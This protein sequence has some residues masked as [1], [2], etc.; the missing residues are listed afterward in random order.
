[1]DNQVSHGPRLVIEEQIRD[2]SGLTVDGLDGATGHVS[3]ASEAGIDRL[4][5]HDRSSVLGPGQVRCNWRNCRARERHHHGAQPVINQVDRSRRNQ[6]LVTEQPAAHN[7]YQVLHH[8]RVVIEAG[9]PNSPDISIESEDPAATQ[10]CVSAKHGCNSTSIRGGASDACMIF[11]PLDL[12]RA[13]RVPA[14]VAEFRGVKVC[15]PTTLAS[16]GRS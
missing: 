7:G 8:P 9:I 11:Q 6:H 1:L 14:T 4:L 5:F 2:S 13:D 15:V 16:S 10:F 3:G 12:H